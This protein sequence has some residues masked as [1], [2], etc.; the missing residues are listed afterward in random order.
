VE[1]ALLVRGATLELL[2]GEDA[3]RNAMLDPGENDG[4]ESFP[5]DNGDGSLDMGFLHYVTV[6]T[7]EPNAA[8]DGSER[9]SVNDFDTTALS[10]LLSE[11]I[12]DD[13]RFTVLQ[14]T[15]SGQP[16]DNIVEFYQ[17]SGLTEEEFSQ[18]ADRL[19]TSDE[20]DL[21]GLVNINTA[22]RE[23]LLCLPELDES[24]VD[25]LLVARGDADTDTSS[26]A[27]TVGILEPEKAAAIGSFVTTR[28]YQFSADIL[29]VSGDGRAFKR[30]RAILD[31]RESPPRVLRWQDL[32]HLGWPIE[33]DIIAGLRAGDL[34][35]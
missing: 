1:E 23:V 2:Y 31:A 21:M 27:W 16:Y 26:V 25:D 29:A 10:E 20:E 9:V 3:N 15:R 28:S 22:P 11:V 30:C 18:L 6:Y 17:R 35:I 12:T 34:E 32:T 8:A 5:D 7:S 24:D 19:T 13:R 33:A 14:A 4:D